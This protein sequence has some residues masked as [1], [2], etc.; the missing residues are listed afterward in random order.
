MKKDLSQNSVSVYVERRKNKSIWFRSCMILALVVV[1]LTSYVLIF[2]ARTEER[3]LICG[4]TEHVHGETCWLTALTCGLEEGEEHSHT[5]DCY[6]TVLVCGME[7]HVHSDDCYAEPEPVPE[8]TQSPETTEPAQEPSAPETTEA[9]APAQESQE[10]TPTAP[11]DPEEPR[12]T[13]EPEQP[14]E[15]EP[16]DPD[17]SRFS[18]PWRLE[19]PNFQFPEDG[20][21]LAP[22]LDS[23][24][25]QRQ[26]GGALVED[27]WFENGETVK[28]AIIY[29]IPKDI[30][31]PDSKYVFYQLPEGIQPIEETSGDV[32]DDGVAVGIYTITEDGIIHILFND[33]F[34]N[35]NA[36]MGTVE[37]SCYLYA[38]DDGSDREIE[39]ENDAGTITVTVPDEQKYDLQ[40]EKTGSFNDDYTRADFLL[41]VSSEKGTGSSLM[42]IDLLTNQTPA[43]LFSAVYDINSFSILRENAQGETELMTDYTV[44]FNEDNMNFT[45][46]GLPAL[47]AGESYK[48]AY[49]VTLD[50]DLSGSFELDN[51][52]TASAGTLEA[53]TSFFITYTCDITKSGSF[54]PMTGLIDW[55][56]TVNPES[57]SVA[58]WR[59]ED[60]LPYPAVGK[61]LLTNANGVRYADLTPSDGRTINYTFPPSA[62]ARPY[63]IRYSTAA[64]T[65]AQTVR[66][67]V[68]LVNDRETTVVAEVEVEER[69]EGVDKVL[70]SKHVYSDGMVRTAWSFHVT[71]PVGEMDSYSFRDNISTPVMD[72]NNGEY[73]DNN[74][75]FAY[76]AE[77]DQALRGNLRMISD[78]QSWY[79]GDENNDYVDFELSYYDSQGR[80]VS[81]DDTETHVSRV[82]F[83]LHPLRGS[84]FHGYEVVAE[85]YPTWLNASSA[86][87]GDYWSYQNYI[88]LRGGVYDVAPAFYRKGNAFEKQIRTNGRFQSE[89]AELDYS[90]CGGVLE[91]RL[92]V[93]LSV[94]EEDSLTVTD[95]LPAGVELLPESP[96]AFFT[97]ANLYGEYNGTFTDE[98]NFS[99][100]TVAQEDGTTL[101]SFQISGVTE[102]M[103]HSYGYIG[104]IYRVRLTDESLWNDYTHSTASFTNVASWDDY[105]A[106]QTVTVENQPKRLEKNGVQ[107]LD[108]EG[109]PTG[110]VRYD[111][112]INAGAEDLDPESDWIVLTDQFSSG[113]GA[114]LD[115]G[116]IQL[117]YYDPSDP[118][119]L[120]NRVMPY[121]YRLSYSAQDKTLTVQI[122]DETA[123]VMVYDYTVDYSAILDNQTMV[124]N[125]ARLAG[126]FES[127]CEI[128]LRGV[129][130][131]ATAWQRVVTLTK[132]DEDNNAKVLPGARF[133]LEYWDPE[134][135]TWRLSE[136]PE[137]PQQI[138]ETNE[139]GR[140]VL[141]LIGSDRDLNPGVLYRMTELRAPV[142]Y[143][144]EDK[145][146]WFL[147]MPR[148]DQTQFQLY[149]TAAAGSDVAFEQVQFFSQN[150]GVLIVTNPFSGLTVNKRW[151]SY[152][153]EEM[154]NPQ[155][156]PITVRLYRSIDPSGEG[157]MDLVPA[158]NQ[159]ENP[160]QLSQESG[161]SYTWGALPTHDE[162]GNVYYYYVAE[163]D[164]PGYI[165]TYINNGITGGTIVISNNCEPYEL[166]ETGSNGSRQFVGLGACL[167]LAAAVAY[168]KF[169]KTEE[170]Q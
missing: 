106:V 121:E 141:T 21:D 20:I 143:D 114:D 7:E 22:Y 19:D 152:Y 104:I 53:T 13:T 116:S 153:G 164:V 5:P 167:M 142:G 8:L 26:E 64:P 136:N 99:F 50:P 25:F 103:K 140:I 100:S 92:L 123:F 85:E 160:V 82:V 57:R 107:L 169:K 24:V 32:M 146:V 45:L 11:A 47:E 80:L 78:G 159:V 122:P 112:I 31:T 30:V 96:R 148:G 161:W 15:P 27:T 127:S 42:V 124:S 150:G 109:N 62:P 132:V 117:Y 29:D 130:S 87:E 156:P 70:D 158:S 138:Y 61:V 88:Y 81:P 43:T 166:P 9:E 139:L 108:E 115:L 3:E 52:A 162:N 113:I 120:G 90:D 40:L 83:E 145:A 17:K 48:I 79:Y 144:L 2:P 28:A 71:L 84:S 6:T 131:S 95:I 14:S 98:S 86:Q 68:R 147:C 59:I 110:R 10:P 134:Q 4:R 56:I 72:V 154:E 91:Y 63:F 102:Q 1:M 66:N 46:G 67:T 65:T 119:R 23:A 75:H 137:N 135:G 163:D 133:L 74:L 35:G 38:N 155:Q 168:I 69:S 118:D 12:E 36:I 165:P 37:F 129:D 77:L 105:T 73:L 55:V 126:V 33:E 94:L 125:R 97:G 16:E 41:T 60:T 76:A 149:E 58:G 51:E 151:F 18:W 44:E 49:A 93:D 34:A 157:E 128:A 89:D 54:N 111:L 39:F 170:K 101:L